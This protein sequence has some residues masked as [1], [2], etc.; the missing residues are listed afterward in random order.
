KHQTLK[1]LDARCYTC[2]EWQRLTR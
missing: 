2:D 1:I